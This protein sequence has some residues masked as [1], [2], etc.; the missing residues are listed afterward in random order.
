MTATTKA[1]F[2]IATKTFY[3]DASSFAELCASIDRHMPDITHHVIVDRADLELFAP[4]ASSRRILHVAEDLLPRSLQFKLRGQRMWLMALSP[5]VRGWIFQQLAKIAFTAQASETAIVHIDSDAQ[6]LRPLRSEEIVRDGRVLY[7][8]K[9][10]PTET[11]VH[12]RW[13]KTAAKVLGLASR[14]WQ[15]VDYISNV[16]AWSPAAAKGMMARIA[17]KSIL[18][19]HLALSW[20]LR[21][22]EYVIYGMF[23]DF[24]DGPHRDHVEPSPRELCHCSWYYD[25][26]K[27]EDRKAFAGDLRDDHAAILVQSNLDL[28][29]QERA[30]LLPAGF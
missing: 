30:E 17:S 8:R 23:C 16:V 22:S 4:F 19:W 15:G 2:A 5:P 25:L 10:F 21:F 24:I 13:L 18:P 27:S 14:D 11:A 7:L 9:D 12:D 20:N 3:K 1:D 26:T 6:F 29:A 28:S